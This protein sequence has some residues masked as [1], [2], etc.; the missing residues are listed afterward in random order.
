MI[1]VLR[2]YQ[3]SAIEQLRELIAAGHRSSLLISPTGSG[4]TVTFSAIVR[5]S[6]A[7][8]KRVIVVAH[9]KELIDQTVKK[10]EDFGVRAGVIMG[11]DARRDSRLAVQRRAETVE[12]Q[13]LDVELDIGA[14]LRGVGAGDD[15]ELRRR[16]GHGPAPR[17]RILQRHQR[18]SQQR[19]IRLVQRLHA[20]DMEHD[21]QLQMVLQVATHT[22]QRMQ[23]GNARV[24]QPG[25]GTDAGTL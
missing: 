10:L 23:D 7:R 6:V 19:M 20:L 13:R 3:A 18:P 11:S 4:K 21:A 16:H 17:Q 2:D 1:P 25:A 5:A 12:R 14:R 22:L 8:G 9:R 15:A 24:L